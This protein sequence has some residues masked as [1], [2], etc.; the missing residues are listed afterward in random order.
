MVKESKNTGVYICSG[1]NIGDAIDTDKLQSIAIEYPSVKQCQVHPV[2]CSPEAYLKLNDEINGLIHISEFA[3]EGTDPNKILKI[4]TDIEAKIISVDLDEH[5]IGLSIKALEEEKAPKKAPK[6]TA[7]KEEEAPEEKKEEE[8]VEKPAKKT[9][10][11]ATKKTA[12]KKEK[13]PAKKTTTKKAAAK[14]TTA[15]TKKK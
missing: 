13:K 6:K 9:A 10:T 5:R 7:K 2:L 14:K 1:C 4:G 12:E 3:E 8:A 15:K 11:K